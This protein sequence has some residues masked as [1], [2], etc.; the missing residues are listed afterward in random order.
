MIVWI[1]SIRFFPVEN[2]EPGRRITN[3]GDRRQ[4]FGS[5]S[6]ISSAVARVIGPT[7]R[8]VRAIAFDKHKAT[9][10]ALGWHQD[11]TICVQDRVETPGFG[12]WTI[13]QGIHHVQPP[14]ALLRRM[15]TVRIHID[16]VANN[17]APLKI[18]L[19]SH[20]IGRV[21]EADVQSH[22]E[23]CSVC[24][25]GAGDVWIYAT[26]ILHASDRSTAKGRRRV[27]QLDY[28]ADELPGDL[29]W[30]TL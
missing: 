4:L 1:N 28:A 17:N 5:G 15:V 9:N 29:E 23:R 7:A 30:L 2:I 14:P 18:A 13:K 8:P 21:D 11:R 26:L 24:L 6:R 12:P 10:W 19:G 16:A 25:A 22:V 20:L 27:L 3:L